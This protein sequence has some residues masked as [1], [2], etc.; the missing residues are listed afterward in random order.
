MRQ[1]LDRVTITGADDSVNPR[2]LKRFQE[3]F[4]FVEW[5]I[6]VSEHKTGGGGAPRF[7]SRRWIRELVGCARETGLR[8]S[9]HLCGKWVR[10]TCVGAWGWLHD[11]DLMHELFM[12]A[13]RVQLNFHAFTHKI[14]PREFTVAAQRT[15]KTRQIIC[16]VDGVND[17]VVSN[18]YDEGADVAGLYDRSG[19]AGTLPEEWPGTLKGIYS[20]YAGGLSPENVEAQ[21]EIISKLVTDPIWIDVE[22]HV[23]SE[24]DKQFDL[25]KVHA[26]LERVAPWVIKP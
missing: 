25:K 2:D 9:I 5:G 19:G 23:R 3:K 1:I 7:P 13:L 17:D 15:L 8:L 26:F 24:D 20:G 6:L 22:S 18:L 4:P 10:Q 16:Q 11:D 21:L 12:T 14:V